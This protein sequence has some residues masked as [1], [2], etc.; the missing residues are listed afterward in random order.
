LGACSRFWSIGLISQFLDHSQMV[1]LLGR[2]I[3]S[4]QKHHIKTPWLLVLKRTIQTEQPPLVG[5][6]G[7]NFC[8]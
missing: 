8:R 2:V 6:V 3:S 5:E 4:S 1:G 7:A